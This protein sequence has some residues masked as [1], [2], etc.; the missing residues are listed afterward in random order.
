MYKIQ[1]SYSNGAVFQ[2]GLE[3][4]KEMEKNE[5]YAD[6]L[7]SDLGGPLENYFEE[8][9][10]TSHFKNVLFETYDWEIFFPYFKCT[11]FRER[12]SDILPN[13]YENAFSL[14]FHGQSNGGLQT[15]IDIVEAKEPITEETFWELKGINNSVC[16]YS[17]GATVEQM[18]SSLIQIIPDEMIKAEFEKRKK[19]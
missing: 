1:I 2:A 17:K 5:D 8:K 10:D 4:F 18:L 15:R 19:K 9:D 16:A 12:Q 13:Y 3:E 7:L 6:E 14:E 11:I